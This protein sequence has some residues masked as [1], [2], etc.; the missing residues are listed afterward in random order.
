MAQ[1]RLARGS[2]FSPG[3][4]PKRVASQSMGHALSRSVSTLPESE[5]SETSI[6]PLLPE[7]YPLSLLTILPTENMEGIC[8]WMALQ[9][10]GHAL[11]RSVSTAPQS[12][13]PEIFIS[14]LLPEVGDVNLFQVFSHLN[15]CCIII[16]GPASQSMG[17]A[18][19]RSR[20]GDGGFCDLHAAAAARCTLLWSL[21]GTCAFN[22]NSAYHPAAVAQHSTRPESEASEMSSLPLLPKVIP[23][24]CCGLPSCCY[25][26]IPSDVQVVTWQLASVM[27][28]WLMCMFHQPHTHAT[29]QTLHAVM[30]LL[31]YCPSGA[32]EATYL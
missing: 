3:P 20:A 19:S 15:R 29:S 25:R 24:S 10:R 23:V 18:L 30:L 31:L 26:K 6:S 21:S 16:K 27:S 28:F 9:S 22:T 11:S 5:A 8:T 32:W 12:E 1:Q 4:P 14:P 7:A 2:T 17:N 13:A